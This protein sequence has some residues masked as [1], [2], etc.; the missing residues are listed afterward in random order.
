MRKLLLVFVLAPCFALA[1]N[2][3]E[4]QNPFHWTGTL[5][6]GKTLAIKNV[7]GDITA[8]AG[9]GDRVEVTAT[10]HGAGSDEI[11]IQVVPSSDGV[12][13]C[14]IFPDVEGDA[15]NCDPGSQW[16]VN[17]H[18]GG[19]DQATV[20]FTV[21]LPRDARLVLRDVNGSVK[22]SGLGE[23]ADAT[24]VNG[25]VDVSTEQWARLSTVNGTVTGHFGR[26][27]WTE[28]LSITTVNGDINLDV[29]ADLSTDFEFNAVNGSFHTDLPATIQE[30]SHSFGPKHVRGTIG[31]GGRQLKLHTVNGSVHLQKATM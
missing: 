21:H 6:A 26:A 24:T 28:P 16:S 9:A 20:D 7:S 31:G 1:Q 13:I 3:A 15:S 4:N 11:R 2:G 17:R 18:G 23:L 14:A 12:A 8:E 25:S 29:P 27:N 19:H 22:A 30:S 10:K 5:A